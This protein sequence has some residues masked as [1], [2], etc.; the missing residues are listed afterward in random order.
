MYRSYTKVHILHAHIIPIHLFI[1]TRLHINK[2]GVSNAAS[3]GV[4]MTSAPK[5]FNTDTFSLL[6]FSGI[7]IIH[8]YPFTAD[9][10]ASPTPVTANEMSG[11]HDYFKC[12][13]D[14]DNM[15][16]ILMTD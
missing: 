11:F 7:H 6:I 2:P 3:V 16:S 4:L 1:C 9:A 8:R 14:H 10:S 12:R 5:A 13:L 15:I